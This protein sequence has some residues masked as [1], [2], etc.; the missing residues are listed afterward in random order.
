MVNL[1]HSLLYITMGFAEGFSKSLNE[2]MNLIKKK[3][4]DSPVSATD[5]FVMGWATAT[6]SAGEVLATAYTD[7]KS[8]VST[9]YNDATGAAKGV[10]TFISGT[11]EK[12]LG[13]GEKLI[14][15]AGDTVTSLGS[16]LSLPLVMVAGIVAVVLLKK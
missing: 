2:S 11:V 3:V 5:K 15:K 12:E 10:G 1:L 7:A 6:G 14:D 16:S 13:L 9:V 4:N 8:A